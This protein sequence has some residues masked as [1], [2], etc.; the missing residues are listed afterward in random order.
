MNLDRLTL[1]LMH[2]EGLRLK[3]Y[4]DTV[5]KTTIGYGRNLDDVGVTKAEA[6]SMLRH[7]I[8]RAEEGAKAL[9]SNF[10]ELT[11]LRQEVLV[12]MAF[13]LGTAGLGGFKRMIAAVEAGD[14]ANAAREISTSKAASQHEQWG[15]PRYAELSRMMLLG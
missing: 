10:G 8:L 6:E 13:N 14:Y 15:N 11:S 5:G 3:P 9:V 2:E 7:D 1:R 12:E 4:K